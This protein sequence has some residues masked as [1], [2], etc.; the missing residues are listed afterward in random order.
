M[1]LEPE[2]TNI[3]VDASL[4]AENLLLEELR[5]LS[6]M[7]FQ[8]NREISCTYNIYLVIVGIFALIVGSLQFFVY[9]LHYQEYVK[10]PLFLDT[11]TIIVLLFGGILSLIFLLRF[12][13]LVESDFHSKDAVSKIQAFYVYYLKSQLPNIE[14]VFHIQDDK[15]QLGRVPS[16]I[17]YTVSLVTSL[18]FSGACYIILNYVAQYLFLVFDNLFWATCIF[19]IAF[20]LQQWYYHKHMSIFKS[21][22]SMKTGTPRQISSISQ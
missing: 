3:S 21:V 16:Y 15:A 8:T 5:H 6:K 19:V 20:F 13:Q 10:I 17:F 7:N 1:Q 14:E 22:P 2:T 11:A 18:S 12:I 9:D 4:K